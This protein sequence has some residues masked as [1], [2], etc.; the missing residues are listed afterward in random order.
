MTEEIKLDK[1]DKQ[2]LFELEYN[3]RIPLTVLAKK[4]SLSPQTV[5]YRIEQ[6]E[7]KGV[8]RKYVAFFDISKFGYQYYRLYIRCEN[9]SLEDEEKIITYFKQHENVVWLVSCS[10]KYDLEV[11]FVARNFINFN[12][13]LKEVYN[14]FPNK[15]HN[16]VTSVSISNYHQKRGY[17]LDKK[18][19]V[20]RCSNNL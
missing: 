2:I 6:L 18:T 1:K 20:Q 12:S 4:V 8:I 16:N 9:V 14:K 10:G 13:M 11:L 7:K 3:A 15:L 19:N 5:K 17:L